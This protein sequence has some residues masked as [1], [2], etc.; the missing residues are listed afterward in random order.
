MR[1]MGRLSRDSG[2]PRFFALL[3]LV[4]R[5][6][7]QFAALRVSLDQ[8]GSSTSSCCGMNSRSAGNGSL[9]PLSSDAS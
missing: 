7:L 3:R 5:H 8:L 9:Q 1:R 2:A 6:A 4:L